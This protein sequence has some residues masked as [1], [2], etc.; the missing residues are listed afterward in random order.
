LAADA[1][2]PRG[3]EGAAAGVRLAVSMSPGVAAIDALES[4]K[5]SDAASIDTRQANRR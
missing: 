1:N 5:P 4:G 2:A 3:I